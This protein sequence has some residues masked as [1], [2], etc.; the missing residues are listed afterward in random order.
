MVLLGG[1]LLLWQ[2][3]QA[4]S[5]DP[6][7]LQLP[8]GFA[9]K[10]I[11]RDMASPT[12]MVFLPGGD[13]LVTERGVGKESAGLAALRLVRQGQLRP[14][15]VLTLS[16]NVT[17]DSGLIAIVL[18]PNFIEN[19]YFYLWYS[20]GEG[21]RGW[22]GESVNRLARFTYDPVSGTADPQSETVILEGVTWSS[23]HNGGGLRFDGAGNLLITTGDA[24]GPHDPETNLAQTLSSLNGK[25][26]RIR[27]LAEGGYA[28]P[29]ENPFVKR[30]V[31]DPTVR[32]E[33]YA[34]GLRNPFRLTGRGDGTFYLLDVGQDAWEEVNRLQPGA[35][36]G[37]PAREGP[38]PIY[39]QALPCEA[40]DARYTDPVFAYPLNGAGAMT[41]LAFYQGDGFPE[42]YHD[43]LFFA[44]FNSRWI[45]VTDVDHAHIHQAHREKSDDAFITFAKDVGLLVDM[46]SY[47]DGLYLLSYLDGAILHLY[48][49]AA[50]N[51]PPT[52]E[53]S[54]TPLQGR[55]PLT[56]TLSAEGTQDSEDLA[57]VYLWNFGDGSPTITTTVPTA[58]VVYGAD[59]VY[60]PTLT[61]SDLRGA[62]AEPVALTVNVYSGEMARIAEENQ[63][64]PGR[65][66]YHGGDSFR[67][68]AMRDSG[69]AGLR[70]D[71]P[72]RW[73]ILQH[74]NDHTHAV[75]NGYVAEEVTFMI[76]L[77]SHGVDADIWFEV[78]LTMETDSGQT[79]RV[80]RELR[81]EVT[82]LA[83]DFWPAWGH[84]PATVNGKPLTRGEVLPLIV[85]HTYDLAAPATLMHAAGV[86]EFDYWLV[87]TSWPQAAAPVIITERAATVIALS[88]PQTYTAYY[89]YL[90]PPNR[91]WLP[92]LPGAAAEA[93]AG[94]AP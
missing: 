68:W 39:V 58:E 77:E 43:K 25:V 50:A 89:R 73:T 29:T 6:Q 53:F 18:D 27:P 94:D 24:A 33:I 8:N 51:L 57:F 91:L 56:V 41:A 87:T 19:H 34:W 71:Q 93:G 44:D 9:L 75:L 4:Q 13:I 11:V 10:L 76:P 69:L 90:R 83:V 78:I 36:Y 15:P 20:I 59:G 17:I 5:L 35:N 92:F 12:D 22:S 55:A 67:F 7:A 3:A 65:M 23:M 16:V 46:E 60:T 85:G 79:L 14:Q 1:V 31:G 63:R 70:P 42:E 86:G 28:I 66:L 61:V 2:P 74:H 21:A 47:G 84:T 88:G 81:P 80:T 64:E 30:A 72:Y 52:P 45:G 38:C 49:D 32:P 82:E 54:A 48:Y 37:W 62:V 26:L 40:A